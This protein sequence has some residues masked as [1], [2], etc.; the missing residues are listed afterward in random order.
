[1]TGVASSIGES[2]RPCSSP[3]L[4]AGCEHAI[5]VPGKGLRSRILRLLSSDAATDPRTEEAAA[6]VELLHAAS[7]VHDDLIDRGTM[8]RGRPAVW[9]SHGDSIA[10]YSG[11][12]LFARATELI[13]VCGDQAVARFA[14]TAAIILEGQLREVVDRATMEAD[15]DGFLA[16]AEHKT[17]ALFAFAAEVGATLANE[18]PPVIERARRFGVAFGI[19]FQIADDVTDYEGAMAGGVAVGNPPGTLYTLPLIYAL[20]GDSRL[21]EDLALGEVLELERVRDAVTRANGLERARELCGTFV[22]RARREGSG[23]LTSTDVAALLD[24]GVASCAMPDQLPSG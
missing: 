3:D 19:A 12:W 16:V 15:V 4:A 24:A 5:G 1:M 8:R 23:L 21:R 22:A 9:N 11:A 7:L 6:A 13:C 20:G 17:A 2:V 18:A 10:A 14:Q